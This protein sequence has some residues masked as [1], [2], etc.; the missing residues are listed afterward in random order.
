MLNQTTVL[1]SVQSSSQTIKALRDARTGLGQGYGEDIPPDRSVLLEW[2]ISRISSWGIATGMQSF[3]EP[4]SEGRITVTLAGE[5]LVVDIEFHV[6]RQDT[7]KPA[8]T[9]VSVKTS[10]GAE[11]AGSIS[12]NAFLL[13]CIQTFCAAVQKEDD[14]QDALEARR[15][16]Q[17]MIEHFKYLMMLETLA[18]AEEGGTRWFVDIEQ[19]C[20]R[21]ESFA[22]QESEA[23]AM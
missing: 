21:L 8:L 1:Q 19:L 5:V 4:E 9:V 22:K 14:Q 2:C 15:L 16:S 12:L 18:K 20:L 23:L 17:K 11:A 10:Y 6:D 13:H 7:L 3:S